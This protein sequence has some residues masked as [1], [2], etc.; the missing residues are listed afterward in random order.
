MEMENLPQAR[1][2]FTKAIELNPN[3]ADAYYD[4][5]RILA[6]T[7][8]TTALHEALNDFSRAIELKPNNPYSWAARGEVHGRL[9]QGDRAIQDLTEAL[10]LGLPYPDQVF[11]YYNRAIANLSQ[12]HPMEAIGDI[13]AALRDADESLRESL[14]SR[15][16]DVV[17]HYFAMA[18]ANV[19]IQDVGRLGCAGIISWLALG[20]R[21]SPTTIIE[22]IE[23]SGRLDDCKEDAQVKILLNDIKQHT[24]NTTLDTTAS[25]TDSGGKGEDE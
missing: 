5:G 8:G 4:R 18:C 22:A 9:N 3:F 19:A 13:V 25:D 14:A 7:E 2:D 15:S 17:G 10:A 20:G 6:T 1:A 11:V 16:T 21:A 23:L 12:V 24:T